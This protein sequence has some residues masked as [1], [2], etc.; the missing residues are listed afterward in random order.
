MSQ[1]RWPKYPPGLPIPTPPNT[2]TQ[3]TP[4]NE[5]CL[6][7]L[8]SPPFVPSITRH[9]LNNDRW[10]GLGNNA[11]VS[12]K[13]RKKQPVLSCGI[14]CFL[15]DG[16]S[17]Y[18][19]E[20]VRVLLV[21]RKDSMSYVEF[22]RGKYKPSDPLYIRS[23]VR[24]MTEG[25][26]QKI[27]TKTFYDIWTEM[28]VTKNIRS[29]RQEYEKSQRR[30]EECVDDVRD[31]IRTLTYAN[32]DP[33]WTFPKGRPHRG[34]SDIVCAKREFQEETGI[35]KSKLHMITKMPL[36]EVYTGSNGIIYETHLFIAWVD[37]LHPVVDPSNQ[38]QVAEV[39][40]VAWI[41]PTE[42][43]LKMRT[44]YLSKEIVLREAIE[45]FLMNS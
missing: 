31:Y 42:V 22:V 38:C 15:N 44:T 3:Q 8:P 5:G 35:D 6:P 24:G 14:I 11:L 28:W 29:H 34:E 41:P 10:P 36:K 19:T 40:D 23:L 45:Q 27:L 17:T 20:N 32:K 37:V 7:P 33:E 9:P 16:T 2:R 1:S 12:Y 39:S 43:H 13:K 25:E 26:H 30:F 21:R 4:T 18:T